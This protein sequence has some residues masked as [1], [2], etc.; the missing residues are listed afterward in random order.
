MKFTNP[1]AAAAAWAERMSNPENALRHKQKES[2]EQP[3]RESRQPEVPEPS[4]GPA[5]E[6]E[7][8]AAPVP[9]APAGETQPT[10]RINERLSAVWAGCIMVG[11]VSSVVAFFIGM[12]R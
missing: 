7:P 1:L 6:A 10:S 2:E 4:P 11:V 8:E 12:I 5:Q 3:L 9:A